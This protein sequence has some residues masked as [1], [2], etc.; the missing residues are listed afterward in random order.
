MVKRR[1]VIITSFENH[2]VSEFLGMYQ[3]L[4]AI[5]Y[6]I[7]GVI[8]AKK[9][10]SK[11]LKFYKKK[12]FKA[13]RIGIF[14]VIN[15][16]RIRN[17]YS[18]KGEIMIHEHCLQF[19]IPHY[20]VNVVNSR[21]VIDLIGYLN[22]DIGVSMG[23]SFISPKVYNLFREGMI[24]IHG[25]LLPD[26]KN[27]Q[28]IIWQIYNR[29]KKSGF[30]IHKINEK[31]DNGNILYKEEIDILFSNTLK[32]TVI[33]NNRLIT[34]RSLLAINTVLSKFDYFSLNSQ[35]QIGG[36]TYTTPNLFQ[37]IKMVYNNKKFYFE[38]IIH[39]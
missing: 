20:F 15:G 17:W 37:F 9:T 33:S 28:G 4:K 38:S 32:K 36:N 2:S 11:T 5:S 12:I 1:I 14:G 3:D 21:E 39:K 22:P 18:F 16:L 34:N 26:Y 31:I 13:A 35:I 24:N 10:V 8:Q 6:E 30:T 27:A 23:N 29:S 19:N 7:V 25:E